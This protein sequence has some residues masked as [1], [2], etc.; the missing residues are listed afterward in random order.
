MTNGLSS[1]ASAVPLMALMWP[2]CG[3]QSGAGR[4]EPRVEIATEG[5]GTW[6]SAATGIER[7]RIEDSMRQICRSLKAAAARLAVALAAIAA[8]THPAWAQQSPALPGLPPLPPA[9][10]LPVPGPQVIVTP[11]LWLAGINTAISTPLAR[12]PTVDTSVGA[13]QLLGHLNA[14][15]FMGSVE[16]RDG[17]FSLLGDVLHVPLGANVTTRNIFYHG[18]NA[19]LTTNIGTALFLWHAVDSPVQSLD[20]GLGFRA[21][22]VSSGLTLNGR[23]LP[24]AN[25]TRTADWADPLVAARYHREL[26]DGFGLTAY[27]DVGGFGVAAHVDWQVVGTLDYALKQWATLRLGYRSLNVTASGS[28]LGYNVHMK[29][30]VIAADF[31]F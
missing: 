13:F 6:R 25:A 5:A 23:L 3:L 29:G 28:T 20:T 22:G 10:S 21:W 9:P 4:A 15:P 24:T 12:A 30:P 14:V 2:A 31:R 8:V 18:G 1:A 11:Y 26:G 16:L 7:Q 27:G 17:P 19:S